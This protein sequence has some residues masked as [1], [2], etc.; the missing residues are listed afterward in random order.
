M[1]IFGQFQTG[2]QFTRAG[3]DLLARKVASTLWVSEPEETLLFVERLRQE[4]HKKQ[5]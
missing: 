2:D 1:V 5:R 4:I 3:N